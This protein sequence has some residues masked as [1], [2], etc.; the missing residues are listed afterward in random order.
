MW[1]KGGVAWVWRSSETVPAI[2]TGL[3]KNEIKKKK[4]TYI[5]AGGTSWYRP[6]PARFVR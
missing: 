5:Q 4:N 1:R 6:V 2:G 3:R